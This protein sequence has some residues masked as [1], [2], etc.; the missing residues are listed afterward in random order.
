M[1]D[2]SELNIFTT[3]DV[4][5]WVN[6]TDE[7]IKLM[8]LEFAS[9]HPKYLTIETAKEMYEWVKQAEKK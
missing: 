7:Q 4:R 6:L 9:R 8:C 2:M 3:L 5:D 1:E